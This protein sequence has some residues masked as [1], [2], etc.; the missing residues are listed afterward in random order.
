MG[1]FRRQMIHPGQSGGLTS[2]W[3][4]GGEMGAGSVLVKASTCYIL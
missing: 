3:D 2:V 4:N 1:H